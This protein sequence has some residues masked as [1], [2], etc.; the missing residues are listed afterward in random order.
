MKRLNILFLFFVFHY[1]TTYSQE[2]DDLDAFPQITEYEVFNHVI[3]K[4]DSIRICNGSPCSGFINDYHPNGVIK[5]KG[6]YVGGIL[7]N[8]YR[9]YHDNGQMER[10]WRVKD[11][12]ISTMTIFY[13]NGKKRSEITYFKGSARIWKD[14]YPNGNI[15]FWEQY[16][17]NF[18]YYEKFNFYYAN[19]NPQNIMELVNRKKRTYKAVEYWENG[20]IKEEGSKMFNASANDYLKLGVWKRYDINGKFIEETN[21]HRGAEVEKDSIIFDDYS[22]EDE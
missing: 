9:N 19:G 1:A 18:N 10:R 20:N 21:F 7:G 11:P 4:S 16:D 3:N 22:D 12:R 2:L 6:F 14:Y 8:T 13:R 15:E 17:K 5:H